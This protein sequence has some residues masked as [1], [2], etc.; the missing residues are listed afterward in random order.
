MPHVC[1]RQALFIQQHPGEPFVTIFPYTDSR[2]LQIKIEK[3]STLHQDPTLAAQLLMLSSRAAQ[4]GGRMEVHVMELYEGG[5]FRQILFPMRT[6]TSQLQD[7]IIRYAVQLIRA[8]MQV[9]EATLKMQEYLGPF[10]RQAQSGTILI[11]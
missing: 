9:K 6:A 10:V 1:I 8:G 4:S 2:G 5:E 11:H 7:A 3:A